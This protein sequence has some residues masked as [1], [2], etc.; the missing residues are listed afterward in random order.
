MSEPKDSRWTLR[1]SFLLGVGAI[2]L[3]LVV[4]PIYLMFHA[5]GGRVLLSPD[6]KSRLYVFGPLEP[7]QGDAYHVHLDRIDNQV[8]KRLLKM[9][10]TPFDTPMVSPRGDKDL[11]EWS[12]ESD[13][14]DIVI[15]GKKTVRIF[16][17]DNEG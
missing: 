9:T 8:E 15:K 10:I 3:V 13:Y 1:P 11:I 14:A 5:Q 17:P 12:P 2:L 7:Q 4:Y 6:G 16:I